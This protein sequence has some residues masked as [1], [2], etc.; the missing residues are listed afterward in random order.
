MALVADDLEDTILGIRRALQAVQARKA[1]DLNRG[2]TAKPWAREHDA[3]NSRNEPVHPQP[4]RAVDRDQEKLRR[5]IERL[6]FEKQQLEHDI[7]QTEQR[8]GFQSRTA[9]TTPRSASPYSDGYREYPSEFRDYILLEAPS[10][11]KLPQG[12]VLRNSQAV[13]S[14]RSAIAD[15]V[16]AAVEASGGPLTA[17]DDDSVSHAV[18]GLQEM[19]EAGIVRADRRPQHTAP[20]WA[21][22]LPNTLYA[23]QTEPLKHTT[24]LQHHQ[25]HR[26]DHADVE[27]GALASSRPQMLDEHQVAPQHIEHTKLMQHQQ[28]HHQQFMQQPPHRL[29]KGKRLKREQRRRSRDP[30]DMSEDTTVGASMMP[31]REHHDGIKKISPPRVAHSDYIG[32]MVAHG[33][34]NAGAWD[35][36]L[37]V[38]PKKPKAPVLLQRPVTRRLESEE[39]EH[40][41]TPPHVAGMSTHTDARKTDPSPKLWQL[42]P[43]SPD[44]NAQSENTENEDF[45]GYSDYVTNVRPPSPERDLPGPCT[46]SDVFVPAMPY[47]RALDMRYSVL[48]EDPYADLVRTEDTDDDLVG[49]GDRLAMEVQ[50]RME[51]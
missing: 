30:H 49:E 32:A 38:S 26:A 34:T 28:Q 4:S 22:A 9:R 44:E 8:N 33:Q 10:V 7:V 31:Y 48:K 19:P 11:L 41:R 1:S 14:P 37:R 47:D 16:R 39:D 43:S 17:S 27:S 5:D 50:R 3:G 13:L 35:H 12:A 25:Q 21:N 20:P 51:V 29:P 42:V 23:Q 18:N 46:C 6:R 2:P 15:S 36:S 45:H 40:T 24:K